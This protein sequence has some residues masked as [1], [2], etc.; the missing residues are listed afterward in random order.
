MILR[1]GL[2]V[3]GTGAP[4]RSGDVVVEGGRIA[5]VVDAG[6]ARDG[7]VVDLD[8]L[9]LAPGFVDIHTHYDAQILWDPDVSPSSAHGVTSIVMGNCGFGIA[10]ARAENRETLI[11]TLENVEG[12]SADALTAGIDWCFE[13]F[14]DYL[15]AL[16]RR[17][18]RV[19]AGA[20]VG[21]SP[22]R[23]D[24]LGSEASDR[25]ASAGEIAT[26]TGLVVDAMRGGA[27][28]LA[29][30]NVAIHNGAY[31]K[32][33]PSR[34]AEWDEHL[35][36]AGALRAVGAGLMEAAGFADEQLEE[37]SRAAGRSICVPG[38]G[39]PD[40]LGRLDR[41]ER[42]G[43][44]LQVPCRPLVFQVSMIDP[45]PLGVI[46]A[47]HEVLA[48][49]RADRAALYRDE[50]WRHRAREGF[51]QHAPTA[52]QLTQFFVADTELHRDLLDRSVMDIAAERGVHPI[53]AL[54]DLA[55][56]EELRTRFRVVFGND[57]I[58]ALG[59]MLRDE[60]TVVGLSDAGAHASQIC[61]AVFA[62]S[63][64]AE[65]VR[66]RGVLTLEQGVRHLTSH[67]A[68]VFGLTGRGSITPG[69]FADL[70]AF[71][72]AAIGH[73][74]LRRVHDLPGGA[75]RLLADS[76][77]IHHMWVNG[78]ATRCDGHDLPGDGARPGHVI[79]GAA[80]RGAKA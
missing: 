16:S 33:V 18:L 61:D 11:R 42:A 79:R 27:L 20:F 6:D 13:S 70:V 38:S 21:H 45:F 34:L 54:V 53:D 4:A 12:M 31:G 17:P 71:D 47:F 36:L 72:P 5:A 14:A 15:D 59:A 44:S 39:T 43:M 62:T 22:V 41:L 52:R 68:S 77:G 49:G 1:G 58:A 67:P 57:D 10:P 75:D 69:S 64:L 23:I 56:A 55:L 74:P 24:V 73:G 19:N 40:A 46:P 7:E 51:D 30:S 9:A 78:T 8:G 25:A 63:L 32:P 35:A 3:D 60:R 66:E 48:A 80:W 65:W 28:G 50:R 26:M 76:I 2:V 29:T 37:L